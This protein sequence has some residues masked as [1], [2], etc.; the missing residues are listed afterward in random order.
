MQSKLTPDSPEQIIE[1]QNTLLAMI[2]HDLKSPMVAILGATEFLMEDLDLDGLE[3]DC[4]KNLKLIESAGQDM[5]ALI[6]N[7]L[8]MARI[9]AGREP[10]DPVR[11]DNLNEVFDHI[12]ETFKY[13]SQLHDIEL[14]SEIEPDLPDVYWDL[15][16]IRYHVI[17][18]IISNALKYTPEGGRV[19]LSAG[20]EGSNVVIRIRDNGP[21]ISQIDRK[22]IFNRFERL[23]VLNPR[24][25]NSSGLGL[26]NANLFVRKHN[27]TITIEDGIEGTGACFT[28]RMPPHPY[29]PEQYRY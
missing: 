20:V 8:T 13:E 15:N 14:V 29:Y 19:I 9:E 24:A 16:K 28:I 23:D 12:W 25:H 4:R 17:N 27:G 10:I 18:N 5:L 21:G 6:G 2:T 7:I 22:R 1:R 3:P 11:I 26:Y